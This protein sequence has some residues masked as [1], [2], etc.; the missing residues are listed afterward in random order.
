MTRPLRQLLPHPAI[1]RLIRYQSLARLRRTLSRFRGTRR[2][3]LSVLAL[4][5]AAVWL[6]QVV[7]SA[8]LRQPADPQKLAVWIPL[9]LLAYSVW[10]L[11]RTAG[12]NPIEPFEW[13]SAE[14]ELLGGA[15]LRR[16]D[17][18]MYRLL[19][20][21]IAAVAKAGLFA[22]VMWPDLPVWL[23]GFAG[24]VLALLF[25]DLLRMV[26][27]TAVYG[28]SR[29]E[30]LVYRFV[31]LA[32]AAVVA[33]VALSD[34]LSVPAAE[35]AG[36]RPAALVILLRVAQGVIE[37]RHTALGATALLPYQLF[38]GVMLST[39]LTGAWAVQLCAT[40]GL[41][42]LMAA[43]VVGLD[44]L[45]LRRR[46]GS[47]RRTYLLLKPN[48]GAQAVPRRTA[49]PRL[50]VPPRWHGIGT[51]AWRQLRGAAHY[52]TSVAVA[53][54][55][56]GV[57]SC[58]TLL[59]PHRGAMMIVQLVGGLVFYTFLLLP[60]A[61][62]F[63]FRRD[64]DRLAVLKAL[65]I[66]PTCITLGQLAVPVL[67]SSLFQA[68]VLLIALLVRPYD[69]GLLLVASLVL[70]PVNVLIF[71]LENLIFLLYPYRLNQEGLGVFFRSILT[72]T[73]KSVLFALGV[74]VA[75]LWAAAASLI[76]SH[77]PPPADAPWMRSLVSVLGLSVLAT[78]AAGITTALL[79]RAYRQFDP[80]QDTPAA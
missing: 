68:V 44:R 53:M 47:E 48:A 60:A 10:H 49:H 5:L 50:R 28:L 39:S 45:V 38:A 3:V 57:L 24:M 56:P 21:A 14:Q 15:P 29:R 75:L 8:M 40:T 67:L 79:A 13:T 19:A 41:V 78:I 77:L 62:K 23:A 34:A 11:L 36:N 20:V 12:R 26:L 43:A 17:L 69:L 58:L 61:F 71:A 66:S 35:L 70:L 4:L 63:D 16:Y 1:A 7:M 76:A 37:L 25:I 9:G 65:P 30:F 64:I 73:G 59:T 51:L 54:L 6:G 33:A 42:L 31:M 18:V 55:A 72:F 22:L 27:E 80:S 46:K 74:V 52:R 2:L 32:G